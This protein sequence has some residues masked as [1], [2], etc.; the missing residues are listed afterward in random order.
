M[1]FRTRNSDHSAYVPAAHLSGP[2]IIVGTRQSEAEKKRAF[3]INF[4]YSKPFIRKDGKD[5]RDLPKIWKD[6]VPFHSKSIRSGYFFDWET[7]MVDG[8][9]VITI[10]LAI[11]VIVFSATLLIGG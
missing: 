4:S 1:P 3:D 9:I 10:A 8:T 6:V 5:V 7:L 2:F 11:V